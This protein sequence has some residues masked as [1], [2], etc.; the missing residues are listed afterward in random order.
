MVSESE[1]LGPVT[2]FKDFNA[3]LGRLGQG[4]GT[5]DSKVQGVYYCARQLDSEITQGLPRIGWDQARKTR[6]IEEFTNEVQRK[7]SPLLNN[8]Y[9]DSNQ[10]SEEIA[11]VAGL[12]T[13]SA[14]YRSF[15]SGAT[16]KEDKME[17]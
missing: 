15:T 4:R 6:A 14:E 13:E 5:G 10:M 1:H 11:E 9:I 8:C 12:L 7:F 2:V 17:R 3:H 16:A